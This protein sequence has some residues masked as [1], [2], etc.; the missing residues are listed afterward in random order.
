MPH[1]LFGVSH[2]CDRPADVQ[3]LSVL[4]TTRVR[5]AT[6][7]AEIDRVGRAVL[8]QP[9]EEVIRRQHDVLHFGAAPESLDESTDSP[10]FPGTTPKRMPPPWHPEHFFNGWG[11]KAGLL[12]QSPLRR[13]MLG[14]VNP[15]S[16]NGDRP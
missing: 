4:T 2:D 8:Q 10:A 6:R 5:P 7:S 3:A 16:R 11:E 9:V 14:G 15:T 1:A 12:A 13:C